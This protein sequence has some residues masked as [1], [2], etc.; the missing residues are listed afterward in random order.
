[1]KIALCLSG[2]PRFVESG[3]EYIYPFIIKNNDVDVFC[4]CWTKGKCGTPEDIKRLYSPA[5]MA[6]EDNRKGYGKIPDWKNLKVIRG[7]PYTKCSMFYSIM[8]CNDLMHAHAN[9]HKIKYDCVIKTRTD[10]CM[11][12]RN[13]Q[14][15]LRRVLAAGKKDI[16][17]TSRYP[18]ETKNKLISHIKRKP[19]DFLIFGKPEA[20][21][22]YCNGYKSLHKIAA[23]RQRYSMPFGGISIFLYLVVDFGIQIKHVEDRNLRV[24]IIRRLVKDDSD[25]S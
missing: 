8:R 23:N 3:Y 21:D 12:Q 13:I 22:L 7:K 19:I 10:I 6:V 11:T 2:Q 20:I 18:E 15:Q 9:K 4:H 16:F 1:M 17:V 24:S 14:K 25:F 5:Q